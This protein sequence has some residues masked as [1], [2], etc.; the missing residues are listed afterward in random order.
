LLKPVKLQQFYIFKFDS[1]RLKDYG[2]DIKINM[3]EATRNNE[4]VSIGESQVI[5]TLLRLKNKEV[6]QDKI[7]ELFSEIKKIKKMSDSEI[8]RFEISRI[9][10]EINDMLLLPE[11]ISI[12]FENKTHYKKIIKDGVFINGKRF[13]RFLAGSG[14]LRRNTV[15]FCDEDFSDNLI[16]VLENGYNKEIKL[17]PSKFNAYFALANSATYNV[18]FPRICVVKDSV[19]TKRKTV[20]Y[21]VETEDCFDDKIEEREVDLEMNYFDGQGLVSPRFSKMW[22]T[23]LG[24]DFTPSSF[25]VR[26]SFLKGMVCTFDFNLFSKEVAKNKIIVDIWGNKKNLDDIDVILTESQ[27]K[28]WYCYDS[29]DSYMSLCN[30]NGIGFGISRVS[31]KRDKT[32]VFSNYQFNQVLDLNN[33]QIESLCAPTVDW[34]KLLS[35]GNPNF[36]ILY[37]LGS[38]VDDMQVEG[39]FDKI[40]D[41]VTKALIINKS[42]MSDP[43]VQ[44]RIWNS[45]SKKIRESYLGSLLHVGNFSTMISDPYAFC[46]HVFGMDVHGLLSEKTYY[47]NFWNNRGV[48]KVAAMRAPLTHQSEVNILY[49]K[50][51][52]D[53]RKWYK[54][55]FTGI[56]YPVDGV[57]CMLHAD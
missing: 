52:R 37:F 11:I 6:S 42:L 15:F 49:L 39:V 40:Y 48:K 47:S 43:Y 41:P 35:Q 20:D 56:I 17:V 13:K 5:R 57:D 31:P 7:N 32:S 46:E 12:V 51:N 30:K 16:H 21:V 34:I 22:A 3:N 10:D 2:Y 25:I 55:I 1:G 27:F 38:M 33:E 53:L 50:N 28:L 18:S 14:N 4:V 36:T 8:N 29:I 45:I 9:T 23:E 19:E 24:L 44:K 26:S 54:Y